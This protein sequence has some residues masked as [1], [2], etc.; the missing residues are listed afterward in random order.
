[1]SKKYLANLDD[2]G[3]RYLA[4][5]GGI[6]S[7]KPCVQYTK[8]RKTEFQEDITKVKE[9]TGADFEVSA[10]QTTWLECG[11]SDVLIE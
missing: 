6:L 11:A 2:I 7:N 5:H 1:M 4:P 10:K 3:V 9:A 8:F